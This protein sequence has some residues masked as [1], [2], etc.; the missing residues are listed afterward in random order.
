MLGFFPDSSVNN[1]FAFD[2][3]LVVDVYIF[4]V[5]CRCVHYLK[6]KCLLMFSFVHLNKMNDV[7]GFTVKR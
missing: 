7:G 6:I 3:A 1:F 4:T 2:V 5:A